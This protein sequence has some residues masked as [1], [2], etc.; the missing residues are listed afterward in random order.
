[1]RI[2]FL[3]WLICIISQ[4]ARASAVLA[5]PGTV[6]SPLQFA[7]ERARQQ[8]QQHAWEPSA[9]SEA[10]SAWN[11]TGRQLL[12]ARPDWAIPVHQKV[13]ILAL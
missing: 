10:S 13:R 12:S 5:E 11:Q 9:A 8:H 6:T 3:T 4:H 2:L 1:M 7:A